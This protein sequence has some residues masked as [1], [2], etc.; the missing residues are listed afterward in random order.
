MPALDLVLEDAADGRPVWRGALPPHAAE[1][2]IADT[3]LAGVL[4]GVL[5]NDGAP[6]RLDAFS[7][8]ADGGAPHLRVE[9]ASGGAAYAKS[10]LPALA[11]R[12]DA[13]V[14][15]ARLIATNVLP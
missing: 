9:V 13:E 12:D 14:I 3:Q 8:E 15:V 1:R 5:P 4:V 6:L 7:L 10:F 11:L 2:L